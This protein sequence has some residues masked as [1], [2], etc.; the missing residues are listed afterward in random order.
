MKLRQYNNQTLYCRGNIYVFGGYDNNRK[1]ITAVEKY[2]LNTNTWEHVGDM[3]NARHS[4]CALA[5]MD[6]IL[7]VG[8]QYRSFVSLNSCLKF[9]TIGKNWNDVARMNDARSFAACTVFE[10]RVVVSGGLQG[11]MTM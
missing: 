4:F 9:D 3:S 8:G 2:S 1:L 10:G 7:I 6:N 11:W 5:F